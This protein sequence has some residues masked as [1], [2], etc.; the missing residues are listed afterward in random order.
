LGTR[1]SKLYIY[2]IEG[3][4]LVNEKVII[5]HCEIVSSIAA[6][7]TYFVTIAESDDEMPVSLWDARTKMFIS[8]LK[9]HE[10]QVSKAIFLS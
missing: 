3:D 7:D 2:K 5:P 9:S 10:Y 4:N 6:N 8:A 1:T